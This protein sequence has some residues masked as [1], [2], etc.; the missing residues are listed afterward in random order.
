[1]ETSTTNI[2]IIILII[3]IAGL[4]DYVLKL[5]YYLRGRLT[6]THTLQNLLTSGTYISNESDKNEFIRHINKIIDY[7]FYEQKSL[8][9]ELQKE[10][11]IISLQIKAYNIINTSKLKLKIIEASD[12]IQVN[13]K[14]PPFM[15]VTIIENAC[16][17]GSVT[18]GNIQIDLSYGKYNTHKIDLSGYDLPSTRD[19]RR[20]KK[21]RGIDFVKQRLS[22]LHQ[23]F[24]TNLKE[25]DY[26]FI[27]DNKLCILIPR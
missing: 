12:D 16:Q 13:I 8:R 1:M 19:V 7:S 15:L 23:H 25:E 20:P 2:I 17:Y 27:K 14:I 5:K 6:G 18:S 3:T 4:I 26:I 24:H 21:D 9:V 11:E 22:F 10:L